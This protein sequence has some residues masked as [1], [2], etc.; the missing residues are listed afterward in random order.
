MIVVAP[1]DRRREMHGDDL[2]AGRTAL[3]PP[4]VERRVDRRARVHDENVTGLKKVG[5]VTRGGVPHV[6][7]VWI[8]HQQA[9]T[10]AREAAS[11][12]RL[13]RHQLLGELEV[14]C[15]DDSGGSARSVLQA[16]R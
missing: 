6:V 1:R 8:G 11:L 7:R 15:V 12:R 14:E 13:T 9:H 3:G 16:N 4:T 10:I 2:S 5:E